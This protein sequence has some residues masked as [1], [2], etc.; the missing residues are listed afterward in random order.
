MKGVGMAACLY[1]ML[2]SIGLKHCRCCDRVLPVSEFRKKGK[3]LQFRC[4]SCKRAESLQYSR[5]KGHL[6]WEDYKA[7]TRPS[8]MIRTGKKQC[9]ACLMV[10]PATAFYMAKF[11]TQDGLYSLCK[12]CKL[13]KMQSYRKKHFFRCRAAHIMQR[14]RKLGDNR[15]TASYLE[16]AWLWKRQR[17]RCA[18]TGVRLTRKTAH[19]D[20]IIPVS[21]KGPGTIDNLQWTHRC[22]NLAKLNMPTNEFRDFMQEVVVVTTYSSPGFIPLSELAKRDNNASTT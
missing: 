11:S 18:L 6:A 4:L 17:G 16:I 7:S 2:I 22:A 5:A 21:D 10:L 13:K 19:L 12:N 1:R 15:G 14:H 9:T 8:D 20:H 3:K